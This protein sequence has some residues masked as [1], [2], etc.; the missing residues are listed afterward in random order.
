MKLKN[1]ILIFILITIYGCGFSSI[2][3]SN[4]NSNFSIN[5]IILEGDS[6]LNN[7]LKSNLIKYQNKDTEI[8]FIVKVE[9][10][11]EKNV[12]TKSKTGKITNY[13]LIGE[14]I[15]DIQPINKKI[16]F[17]EEK[18]MESMSDKF[19][20][21]KYEKIIKQNFAKSFSDKLVFEL[22]LLK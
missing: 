12:L 19:Q 17:K 18:I 22:E 11:Y 16:S 13:E 7:Y 21:R 9:T 4:N 10:N 3:L 2:Y 6:S 5:E 8:Q 1:L 14:V 15:F 20:E